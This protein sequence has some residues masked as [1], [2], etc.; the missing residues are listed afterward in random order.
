MEF[1]PPTLLPSPAWRVVSGVRL[2]S[3]A[4]AA[5]GR[6]PV[7]GSSPACPVSAS[8]SYSWARLTVQF[9]ALWRVIECLAC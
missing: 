9:V 8:T 1:L 5:R 7:F 4:L 2:V 6:T 3:A